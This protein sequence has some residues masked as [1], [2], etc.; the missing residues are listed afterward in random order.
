MVAVQRASWVLQIPESVVDVKIGALLQ[1]P[2]GV[3][4]NPAQ[5]A[6]E[7]TSRV[8]VIE[9]VQRK[10][11]LSQSRVQQQF[12]IF[13]IQKHGIGDEKNLHLMLVTDFNH[14]AQF[15]VHQRIAH[16]VKANLLRQGC[17]LLDDLQ[18]Q[19]QIHEFRTAHDLGAKTA[20]Q[21]ANVADLNIDLVKPIHGPDVTFSPLAKA[22]KLR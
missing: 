10:I 13:I 19:H 3:L 14:L 1:S 18:K 20:L 16:Q 21:V 15:G 2:F 8:V 6:F 12:D 11:H 22:T 17:H 7:I 9:T 5:V 4:K